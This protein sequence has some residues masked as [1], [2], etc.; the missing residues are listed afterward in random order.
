[1]CL[2][3]IK[4]ACL[5]DVP[6]THSSSPCQGA[7]ALCSCPRPK[8]G[9]HPVQLPWFSG[10]H[11]GPVH[12]SP[13]PDPPLPPQASRAADTLNSTLGAWGTQVCEI[14]FQR[15]ELS[16]ERGSNMGRS[17]R[18]PDPS[19]CLI[20]SPG[21]TMGSPGCHVFSAALLSGTSIC[22]CTVLSGMG[23]CN[24]GSPACRGMEIWTHLTSLAY[25]PFPQME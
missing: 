24:V 11:M 21:P 16:T 19:A 23:H 5:A 15:L 8:W 12:T 1:M 13:L 2:C 22:S 4:G 25:V 17:H 14:I 3:G 10:F 6:N 9:P 18:T 7:S 20:H